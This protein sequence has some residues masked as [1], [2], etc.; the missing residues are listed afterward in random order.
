M[1]AIFNSYVS[2]YQRVYQLQL[3]YQ[4]HISWYFWLV[5]SAPFD[6]WPPIS[7][8]QGCVMAVQLRQVNGEA[9]GR[10]PFDSHGH[11]ENPFC[12][13]WWW[14]DMYLSIYLSIY[15]Y[16]Y[17]ENREIVKT[18]MGRWDEMMFLFVCFHGV[19]ISPWT[20]VCFYLWNLMGFDGIVPTKM[21]HTLW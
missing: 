8:G 6:P 18:N 21:D 16:I 20:L 15:I 12:D 14:W 19:T 1:V 4:P 10:R 17:I 9:V 2:R 5:K 13:R 3:V 7:V 11:V